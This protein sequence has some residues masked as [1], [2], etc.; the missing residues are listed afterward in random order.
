VPGAVLTVAEG[1][2]IL[3][4]IAGL[5][6]DPDGNQHGFVLRRGVYTAIDVPGGINTGVFSINAN[7]EIVGSYD[8]AGGVTHG[9]VGTLSH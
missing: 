2:N 9:Y 7:G 3:R 1:I 5:Y 4:Q 6:V 8:D